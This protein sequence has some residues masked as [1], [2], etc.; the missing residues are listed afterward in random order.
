MKIIDARI[1]R[2]ELPEDT[3]IWVALESDQGIVGWGEATDGG[4]AE[5]LATLFTEEANKLMDTDPRYIRKL[6]HR[7]QEKDYHPSYPVQRLGSTIRS[8]IDQALWDLTSQ[9]YELP[10]HACLG[11]AVNPSIPLYA[12]LNRGLRED[13]STEGL[14]MKAKE[15]REAGISM[16]KCTPFDELN[17]FKDSELMAMA[18][19]RILALYEIVPPSRVMLDC[20][21]R[22]NRLSLI[23]LLE[24]CEKH[25]RPY[26]IED[27][28]PP[29]AI[30]HFP[31][32]RAYAPYIRWAAGEGVLHEKEL[33]P[34]LVGRY[35]DVLMPDVK[36]AGGVTALQTFI[37]MAESVGLSISL[38]NPTS[39]IST[40]FSAHLT[41]LCRHSVPM[42]YPWGVTQLR[43]AAMTA[44]EPI[45][46]GHYVLSNR[47][48]IGMSPNPVFMNNFGR[49]WNGRQ[50]VVSTVH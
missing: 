48:G 19:S 20:H 16:V 18:F 13:R 17:P 29:E 11:G 15:A 23:A 45:E 21:Q 26:W 12:N 39:P 42:E 31:E 32:I 38:H 8:A 3:W 28:L 4:Q 7:F 6:T 49:V 10:L 14:Q 36:H 9:S 40:A 44:D 27:P 24:W 46:R 47:P 22:L 34:Y 41:S 50:F 37:S 43:S 5:L 2:I 1:Y 33:V 25:G 30:I 35:Y